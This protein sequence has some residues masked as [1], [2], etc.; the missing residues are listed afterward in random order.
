VP[1]SKGGPA[2]SSPFDY[3]AHLT[4][5]VLLGVL[6]LRSG[7]TLEWDGSLMQAKGLPELEPLIHGSYRKG[8]EVV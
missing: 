8:W 2:A 3:A 7:K 4:E 5:I 1:P 6:S